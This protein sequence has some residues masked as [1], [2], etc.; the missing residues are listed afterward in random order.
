MHAT[1]RQIKIANAWCPRGRYRKEKL[2]M[3]R[4]YHDRYCTYT[5]GELIGWQ[6]NATDGEETGQRQIDVEI[7]TD[8]LG[9]HACRRKDVEH[10]LVTMGAASSSTVVFVNKT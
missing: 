9:G 6:S 4:T 8:I 10:A 1:L 7:C 3:A 2:F 5:A